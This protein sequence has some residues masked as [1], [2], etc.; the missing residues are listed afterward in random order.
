[1]HPL[2]ERHDPGYGHPERPA[3]YAAVERAVAAAGAP[4][5][6]AVEAPRG[7]LEQVH[8]AAYLSAVERLAAAGGGHL[9]PDTAVNDASFRAAALA[10][11]AALAAVDAVIDGEIERAFCGGRP[12]GHHAERARAMGFCLINHAAVAAAHARRSSAARVAILDW[13]AHHGNGT[14]AIFYDDPSVLYVSLHQWPFYP[15]TGSADQRGAGAAEGATVNVPVPAG[16][17]EADYLEL[18]D[19]VAL[20][21]VRS[22]APDLLIVSAGFDAHRDDPLCSLGLTSGAFARMTESVADIGSGQVFVLE[23]GYDLDALEESVLA[24][25][26]I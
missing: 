17:G 7:D 3:R 14:Q 25:L 23:G 8:D 9:D 1:M 10:S 16:I 13:D 18:F 21:A 12:P 11:G 2:F 22:F 20:P 24:V 15:G 6:S 5:E 19:Q 4:V 26:T